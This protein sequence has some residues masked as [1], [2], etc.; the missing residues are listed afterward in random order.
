MVAALSTVAH[1]EMLRAGDGA[2]KRGAH[3]ALARALGER[4]HR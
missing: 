1:R 2:V 3:R 4:A